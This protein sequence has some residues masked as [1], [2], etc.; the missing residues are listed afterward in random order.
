[1]KHLK[2]CEHC[3]KG[4]TAKRADAKTC[5]SKCRVAMHK[6]KDPYQLKRLGREYLEKLEFLQVNFPGVAQRA[7]DVLFE[8]GI[9]L[10]RPYINGAWAVAYELWATYPEQ[11]KGVLDKAQQL[12]LP[13]IE[14]KQS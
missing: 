13:G 1:M 12:R 8:D 10:A 4:F 3:G 6:A 14:G 7:K 9:A 11:F 2:V 5:S